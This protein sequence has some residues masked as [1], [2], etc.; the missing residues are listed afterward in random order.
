MRTDAKAGKRGMGGLVY[1]GRMGAP[2][3]PRQGTVVVVQGSVVQP[4]RVRRSEATC[5]PV[6]RH[7]T[8]PEPATGSGA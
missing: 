3:L 6:H 8:A 4:V 1:Y 7:A 2:F 5:P